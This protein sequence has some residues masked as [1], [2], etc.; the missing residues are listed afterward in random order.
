MATATMNT[1]TTHAKSASP[2]TE[3]TTEAL[4]KAV[5]SLSEKASGGE[6]KLRETLSQSAESM[7]K[8][9]KMIEEKW[10]SSKVRSF[11]LENPL[12]TAGIAFAAG[13]LLTSLLRNK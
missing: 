5:D 11:A 3:K 12:A 8:Q 13:A 7:A 10:Q 2:V 4:H 9:Q 6:E 1:T